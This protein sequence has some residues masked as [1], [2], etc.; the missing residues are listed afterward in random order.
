MRA[1]LGQLAST[2]AAVAARYEHSGCYSSPSHLRFPLSLVMSDMGTWPVLDGIHIREWQH[3]V[4]A[5]ASYGP[6]EDALLARG[7][8]IGEAWR[9]AEGILVRRWVKVYSWSE[10][11]PADHPANRRLARQGR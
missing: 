3:R 11:R 4:D 2:L 7:Y 5:H 9:D 1:L 8:R 6:G 10:V